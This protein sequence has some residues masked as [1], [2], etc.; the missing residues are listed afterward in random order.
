M[1]LLDEH[2]PP[3]PITGFANVDKRV[4]E[5]PKGGEIPIVTDPTMKYNGS[6]AGTR[7]VAMA[8]TPTSATFTDI[9]N[10]Y[11]VD[12]YIHQGVSK[13]AEQIVREG[14]YLTGSN[15]KAVEYVKTRL[16][17]MTASTGV[18]WQF[19]LMNAIRDYVKF[20]NGF[21]VKARMEKNANIFGQK[22]AGMRRTAGKVK[23]PVGG[24]YPV[25]PL[26]MQPNL[27][28]K[29]NAQIG[30]KNNVS[31]SGEALFDLDD[32][33]QFA[34]DRPSGTIWGVSHLVPVLDDVRALRQMEEMIVHL[35]FK[36]LNPLIHH[37]VPDTTG[38]G[39][40][41]QN[42]VDRAAAQ[43]NV[44]AVN[45]YICTPPGHKIQVLGS[46]SKALRAEGY[47]KLLKERVF[48]G[49]GLS[50]LIMGETS[51]TSVGSA[52][53]FSSIMN[54]RVKFYQKELSDFI[55]YNM[56]WELLI[57]GGFD[58]IFNEKDRVYWKFHDVDVDRKIREEAHSLLLY[59]GNVI[60]EDEMRV[61]VNRPALAEGDRAKLY[62]NTVQIPLAKSR[63]QSESVSATGNA[64]NDSTPTGS[65]SGPKG[66]AQT[67]ESMFISAVRKSTSSLITCSLASDE[68]LSTDAL[69]Q[70]VDSCA[71][72]IQAIYGDLSVNAIAAARSAVCSALEGA[73]HPVKARDLLSRLHGWL[74]TVTLD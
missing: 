25:S 36:S 34:Y 17:M 23:P 50:G 63:S 53:S 61:A 52:D 2:A 40:G 59:Q 22:K 10:G 41:D 31:G 57:E 19:P 20:G 58:P 60:T 6:G 71:Q 43:H 29:T 3:R 5:A 42:D 1:P 69:V 4:S 32:V 13:Y 73:P 48:A 67:P 11:M 44:M 68:S 28:Q 15:T 14:Y 54:D 8:A 21:L 51:T 26:Y 47:F 49:L 72:T 66:A 55:T 18:Y 70:T 38:T 35:V 46:E 65:S 24:Y 39:M 16:D 37:E 62:L 56:I 30:W 27:D 9:E 45:G 7:T 33:V 64:S 74:S 12:S